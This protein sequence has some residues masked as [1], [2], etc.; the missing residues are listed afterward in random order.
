MPLMKCIKCSNQYEES[1][2][3]AYLCPPCKEQRDK[4]AK[5]IDAKFA[6]RISKSVKTDLQRYNELPK[7]RG[8]VNAK[9]FL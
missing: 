3:E 7:L 4:I 5:E 1:D 6:G 9:D 2:V 8:F